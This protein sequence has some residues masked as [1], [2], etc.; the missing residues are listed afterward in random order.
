MPNLLRFQLYTNP[1][2]R[3][4]NQIHIDI[5]IIGLPQYWYGQPVQLDGLQYVVANLSYVKREPDPNQ[6][7][8]IRVIYE[9]YLAALDQWGEFWKPKEFEAPPNDD[10]PIEQPN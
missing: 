10:R 3:S 9:V 1:S 6:P 8:E 2:R 4:Y 7:N 5:P